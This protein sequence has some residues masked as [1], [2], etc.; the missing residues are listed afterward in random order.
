MNASRLL[1][2][3]AMKAG[4]LAVSLLLACQVCLAGTAAD[5]KALVRKVYSAL[6]SGD[7]AVI[8][9]AFDPAG[10]SIVGLETRPRGGPF[11]TFA[12]AAPFPAALDERTVTVEELIAEDD[13][14]AVR[15]EICGRHARPLLTFAPTGKRICARYLNIFTVKDGRIVVNAVGMDRL[16][17]RQAL[18]AN[19]K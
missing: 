19:S 14:V 6:E 16:Q 13:K 4:P 3:Y 18:E 2:S 11:D 15:S 17:L 1:T 12:E 8:N 9:Q 7:V 10:K 5:N